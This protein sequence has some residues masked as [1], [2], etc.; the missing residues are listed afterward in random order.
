MHPSQALFDGKIPTALAVC[1]HYCGTE[2]RMIKALALQK[3][4]GP[5]FDITFDCE[6]GA[7]VGEEKQHAQL[8]SKLINS[9]D[10][11]FN[12]VGVRVHD[13]LSSYFQQDLE[14]II[15]ECGERLSSI[16][17]PKVE[18]A[19]QVNLLI[20]QINSF[21]AEHGLT[22]S[23]PIHVLIET[24]QA[25]DDVFAIAALPQVNV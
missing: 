5:C 14:M 1:D 6:D 9:S 17:I 23:I 2:P 15:P 10:N 18:S 3:E 11:L 16:T 20:Q 25:L 8:V 22:K 4:L 7:P 24:H 21:A 13:P 12:R 19:Q